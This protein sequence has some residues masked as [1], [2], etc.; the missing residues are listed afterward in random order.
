[1]KTPFEKLTENIDHINI[2]LNKVQGC[3]LL[4]A[5]KE[6]LLNTLS[7]II[8]KESFSKEQWEKYKPNTSLPKVNNI[9]YIDNHTDQLV[10]W[11]IDNPSISNEIKRLKFTLSR[12][13]A[14]PVFTEEEEL[15]L[16][17]PINEEAILKAIKTYINTKRK[18]NDIE[19]EYKN[20]K[21]DYETAK[22]EYDYLKKELNSNENYLQYLKNDAPNNN[23]GKY[24][25]LNIA[26]ELKTELQLKEKKTNLDS[27]N[28]KLQTYVGT[29]AD[30]E[31]FAH[32]YINAHHKASQ[33]YYEYKYEVAKNALQ[34][35]KKNYDA[36]SILH[37]SAEA[38]LCKY[39]DPT[40]Q[41]YYEIVNLAE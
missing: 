30:N 34:D 4:V 39:V 17:K 11:L 14:L 33:E 16:I 3:K 7:A 20:L 35:Y 6:R 31:L 28:K 8:N 15:A 38:E 9:N 22:N 29:A 37:N 10:N 27:A 24:S 40:S 13:E 36:I 21:N 18:F 23:S 2:W 5:Q 41:Q 32:D 25:F 26:E 1:M 19:I 12:I